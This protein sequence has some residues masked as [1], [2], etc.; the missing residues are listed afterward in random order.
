MNSNRIRLLLLILFV[1]VAGLPGAGHAQLSTS[2][3]FSSY[4][5]RLGVADTTTE[6]LLAG[7][8]GGSAF[9][10]QPLE[11]TIDPNTYI[12]GPGDGLYLNV[13]AMHSLDQDLTVTPEGKVIIPRI[14]EA[15][16]AG[17]TLTAA[18]KLV[19]T[20]LSR[21]YKT[22][23]ATLSMR[24]VRPVKISLLGEVLQPGIQTATVLQRVSEVIDRSGGMLKT[25]SLRGIEIRSATG[26][27]R[28]RA[29]L[30]RYYAL[31]DLSA[32]PTIEG[33]DV[34]IVPPAMQ[35]V[36]IYGG[37]AEPQRMEFV[38]GDSL[39]TVIALARGLLPA[40]ITDSI[41]LAR[42]SASDPSHA[43][44]TYVDYQHGQNPALQDG[45]QIFIRSLTQ[46]HVQRYASVNGEVPFP[47]RFS[48]EPGTTRLK[49][50]LDRAGG[51][52]PTAS[53]DEAVLIRR[54]GVGS[55][56]TDPEFRRI[57]QIAPLRKEGMTEQ[58]YG[59][60]TARAD[61]FFRST[62]V[63]NFKS[64]MTKNDQSQ[65]ILLR[66]QDSIYIPRALGYVTVS[67]SVNQQGNVVYIEGGAY[68]DYI[69]KAG[70]FASNADRGAVRVV[71]PKTGSYIDPRSSRDYK[72][73]PGD[74]IIV[75]AEHSEFWKDV[76]TFTAL[77]AQVLT[78]VA[79]IYLLLKK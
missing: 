40:A 5:N 44:R 51:T 49:D 13:Y 2:E 28:A 26:A 53:L 6:K 60:Y 43:Q 70:G 63:V 31:G 9:E 30:L 62:M 75:P 50:L 47:G 29:D 68:E 3:V 57:M 21:E 11:G 8:R 15:Q 10:S 14:G 71:N 7:R 22:P 48:I 61:Q 54:V 79:G 77:T 45:D 65:N 42:F 1:M 76:A 64:L 24:R 35:S 55:W 17:L 32:N 66:E 34:I 41:E 4:Q 27:I 52:L 72:I 69:A 74:M 78:L 39:S 46:Y 20:L 38:Q 25:S 12:L 36:T 37:V 33:G 18:Q 16:V 59:Y 19:A 73:A 67:G 58:E 56:E 23:D